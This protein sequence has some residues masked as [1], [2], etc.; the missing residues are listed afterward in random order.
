VVVG[1]TI[2]V[3]AGCYGLYLGVLE[4][5][6]DE[7][8]GRIEAATKKAELKPVSAGPQAPFDAR[9]ARI[10]EGYREK[11]NGV[12]QQVVGETRVALTRRDDGE[13]LLGDVVAD[14]MRTSANAEIA[15]QNSGGIRADIPPGRITMEQVYMALPFDDLLVSMDT[16]S[17]R[18]S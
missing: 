3:Q 5:T 18:A 2:V 11:I 12:F 1:Q 9:I 13:S 6:V 10:A 17:A 4:L 15:I 14:A 8:T 16:W 7:K